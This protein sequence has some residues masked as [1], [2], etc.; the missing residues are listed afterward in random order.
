MRASAIHESETP[1][2]GK[3]SSINEQ[4]SAINEQNRDHEERDEDSNIEEKQNDEVDL[5]SDII[6]SSDD[7][8]NLPP[9]QIFET[10][11]VIVT[12]KNET[13]TL[14]RQVT[15][16]QFETVNTEQR[17]IFVQNLEQSSN[18]RS[19]TQRSTPEIK[20]RLQRPT[21]SNYIQPT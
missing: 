19:N 18:D 3:T 6:Q 5:A 14:T 20:P 17:E 15:M 10:E 8:N 2:L 9:P 16:P 7:E 12:P 13:P 1:L 21:T 4:T 11:S